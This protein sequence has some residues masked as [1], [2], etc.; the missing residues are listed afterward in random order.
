MFFE[1]FDVPAFYLTPHG[2]LAVYGAGRS[3]ALSLDFG[4]DAVNMIY[5][6]EGSS[7]HT[8]FCSPNFIFVGKMDPN[9]VTCMRAGGGHCTRYLASLL[10]Y[11]PP[12]P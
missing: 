5:V 1:T 8:H 7:S 11:L 10:G 6:N 12:A 9:E 3:S 4:E 2:S